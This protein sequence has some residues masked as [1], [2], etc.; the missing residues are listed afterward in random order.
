VRERLRGQGATRRGLSLTL[1]AGAALLAGAGLGPQGAA[2]APP[3]LTEFC[4]NSPQSTEPLRCNIPRGIGVD[5]A[6]GRLYIGDQVN[7]R[8]NAFTAWGEA[9]RSWGWDV[10]ASGPGNKSTSPE[11]AEFEICVPADG[12]VCK[13]GVSGGGVGQI[14]FPYGLAVDS[15]GDVYVVDRS[16][17][18]V[19]KFSP[20]GE[21]LLMFGGDVNK[22]TGEEICTAEDLEGGDECGPGVKGTDPGFFDDWGRGD[23]IAIG[24]GPSETIYVGDENR[25]QEFDTEGNYIGEIPFTGV[26]LPEPGT[27]QGLAVDP[28]SGDIYFSY[29]LMLVNEQPVQP[30]VHRLDPDTGEVLDTLDVP[31]PT[32]VATDSEGN[33]YAFQDRNNH[34]T[35]PPH[36]DRAILKFDAFGQPI[37]GPEFPIE[38]EA[39]G[40]NP[41]STGLATSSACEIDGAQLLVSS[42]NSTGFVRIYGPP[43][44]DLEAP[45]EPPPEVPPS[46]EDQYATAV[47]SGEATLRAQIN[48][49]FW[50][51]TR[52]HVEYG[53][54]ECSTPGACEATAPAPPELLTESVV[55][56]PVETKSVFLSGLEPDTTY[57]YRFVAESTFTPGSEE[58]VEVRGVGGTLAGDGVEGTFTTYPEPLSPKTDC[59][60]QPFRED[61]GALLPECR[62]YELVSP[63]DKN[64]SDIATD[65]LFNFDPANLQLAAADGNRTTYSSFTAFGDPE[66]A[67]LFSQFLSSRGADGWRTHSISPPRTSVQFFP[68]LDQPNLTQFKAFSEDLCEGW[69]IQDTDLTLVEGAPPAV[70]SIYRRD[71]QECGSQGYELITNEPPPGFPTTE[72]L[73]KAESR[74][75]P[76]VQGISADSTRTLLR[77]DAALTDDACTSAPETDEGKG[78]QQLYLHSSSGG[79][80]DGELEL[81]SLLPNGDA[82]CTHSSGGTAQRD[83]L[84]TMRADSVH[85]ALSADGTRVFW[86]AHLEASVPFKAVRGT[87]PLY[88]RINATEERSA[89]S[90]GAC[91][92]ATKA[93]TYEVS[94]LISPEP[95]R[96]LVATPDGSRALFSLDPDGPENP[97]T[98]T[99][100]EFASVV[101]EDGTLLTEVTPIVDGFLGVMGA[102]SDLSRVYFVSTEALS[103]AQQ[104]SEEEEAVAGEPNLYLRERGAELIFIGRLSERDVHNDARVDE[105]PSPIATL[106]DRRVARVSPDGMHAAFA[107]AATLTGADNADLASGEP[108]SEVFLYDADPAGGA[109][110]LACISCN[111]SGTRPRGRNTSSGGFS[112]WVASRIIGWQSQLRPTRPLSTDG[113]R[114]FF[115][116][117]QPL[118]LRDVNGRRDVYQWV[119]ASSAG[120]CEALGAELH[121]PEAGGCIS[122]ISSGK[123]AEDSHFFDASATGS[124]VFFATDSGLVAQDDFGLIDVYDARVGGGFPPPDPED[125]ICEGEAC[126]P[127]PPA[128]PV[129]TPGSAAYRGPG[130]PPSG[131]NPC[132]R[133]QRKASALAKRLERVKRAAERA[134]D[135]DRARALQRRSAQLSAQAKRL[136]AQAKRCRARAN[137][138]TG[139]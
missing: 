69:F 53:T 98:T 120:Q 105:V 32:A 112:Y 4:V 81:V 63:L 129:S 106:P 13:G 135:P 67:P 66:S 119:R 75:A 100:Y 102:S 107:S 49:N 68:P 128:P 71:D 96:F 8:V 43:A 134:S 31:T 25:I 35:P 12:D 85:N 117:Y 104:N 101:E 55:K 122:L 16:N 47:G 80:A 30:G 20:D 137:G 22:T 28:A 59:P 40:F 76:T 99:A 52:Y 15:S 23:Y 39:E 1:L 113:D 127:A 27:V 125:P 36:Y 73:E 37:E 78:I 123:S 48:P 65:S 130:N 21:F 7:R 90:A 126:Q 11:P 2:A 64:N 61:F 131:A 110:E 95:A 34:S 74:Y 115:E 26:P 3:E 92:E 45:C 62:A 44:Q 19:Q 111:R 5:P 24:P 116:S 136:S 83:Q 51:T 93:C 77:A 54:S 29:D 132:A 94:E 38:A 70:P 139:Q 82:A 138:R 10:V 109:G 118:V 57:H 84:G 79:E 103:G 33:V 91:T 60:N 17:F 58:T 121:V 97:E 114:L 9:R 42:P 133:A 14:T 108:D 6:N 18:R 46:I 124:D 72:E 87:G 89:I 41:A 50:P 56:A 86:S 88:L